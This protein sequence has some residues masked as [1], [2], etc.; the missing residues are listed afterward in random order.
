[1]NYFGDCNADGSLI[2]GTR[3]ARG[4]YANY[5]YPN[6][7]SNCVFTC[8]GS[9]SQEVKA[10]GFYGRNNGAVSH[11]VKAAIF[12]NGGTSRVL[13]TDAFSVPGGGG[14]A[15]REITG[16]S[17]TNLTGGVAYRLAFISDSDDMQF[18]G[19]VVSRSIGYGYDGSGSYSTPPADLVDFTLST[20]DLHPCY[21][22]GV[23]PVSSGF[24]L[25]I[26]QNYYNQMRH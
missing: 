10:L 8:P 2:S 14:D 24:A 21:R 19:R 15:W 3:I 16:L 22:C 23:D 11:N 9:G 1:M 5:L 12:N 18:D 7:G 25:P 13:L 20:N 26:A 4:L 17:G 6:D